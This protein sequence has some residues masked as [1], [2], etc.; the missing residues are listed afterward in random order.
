M[1]TQTIVYD[2]PEQ[3][4]APT[5]CYELMLDYATDLISVLEPTDAPRCIYAN[6]SFK[7]I[8]GYDPSLLIGQGGTV[9]VYPDDLELVHERWMSLTTHSSA[10]ATIR[11][12]HAD[13]SLRWIEMRWSHARRQNSTY[14]I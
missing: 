9:L 5:G 11:Y 14:I 4:E 2:I 6:A 10:Q 8:L 12:R 1:S 3:T 13:D 7:T